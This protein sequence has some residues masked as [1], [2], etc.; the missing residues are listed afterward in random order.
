MQGGEERVRPDYRGGGRSVQL[1]PQEQPAQ[2]DATEVQDCHQ[3]QE[4][5]PALL[6]A[7]GQGLFLTS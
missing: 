7:A 5:Q 3:G 2:P 1:P 4:R 6:P